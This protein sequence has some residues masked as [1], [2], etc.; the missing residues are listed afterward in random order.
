MVME[1]QK[2]KTETN[3]KA[4]LWV[5]SGCVIASLL[6]FQILF[7]RQSGDMSFERAITLKN[8]V[9]VSNQTVCLNDIVEEGWIKSRCA[10]DKN[11][12]C[13]WNLNGK[14][15]HVFSK[16][17]IQKEL[18]N[19]NFG[20]VYL[21]LSGNS[22]V[23]VIQTHRALTEP[24]LIL[25]IE[26]ALKQKINTL[27]EAKVLFAKTA[28]PVFTE[29]KKESDWEIEIPDDVSEKLKEGLNLK[30]ISKVD[31]KVLGWVQAKAVYSAN[32]YVAKNT[33]SIGSDI[34]EDNFELKKVELNA[35]SSG[36]FIQQNTFPIGYRSKVTIQKG[37]TLRAENIARIPA[38]KLGDVVTLILKSESLQISTKGVVQGAASIG[39]AVTVML[40]RYKRS[41][42]GKVIEGRRVEVKL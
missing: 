26:A 40:P 32:T 9:E 6:T 27:V 31:K 28:L 2:N 14:T 34:T 4:A 36:A 29:L 38:V 17:E 3:L 19:I 23:E 13:R 1:Y 8:K 18:G 37:E 15:N 24:E 21:V 41:F 7:A 11:N 10:V 25:N 35:Q 20:G 39:E 42:R 16:R 30:I 12:C 5:L 33:I 22:T